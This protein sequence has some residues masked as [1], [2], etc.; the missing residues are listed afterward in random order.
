[1]KIFIAA[2]Y[3]LNNGD[4]AVLASTVK[5]IKEIYPGAVIIVSAVE[6]SRMPDNCDF[7]TVGWP[8]NNKITSAIWQNINVYSFPEWIK[9]RIS[10]KICDKEYLRE[11]KHAD[12][13]LLSGGHH[14]TDIL[15]VKSYYHLS[16]N[17][18]LPIFMKKTIHLL[19]QSIGPAS[20]E[21]IALDIKE[22]LESATTVAY[23]DDSS[24]EFLETLHG[25]FNKMEI[26]DLVY[27]LRPS[28]VIRKKDLVA[29]AL[30]HSYS[31]ERRNILDLTI[32]NLQK[33]IKYLLDEGKIVTI[34]PM[35]QGDNVY[36][37]MIKEALKDS[38]NI[39]NFS[40]GKNTNQVQDTID[41]FA[42]ASCVIAYKTHASIFS[43]ISETPLIGVAYHPK[44]IEF[45]QSMDLLDYAISDKEA[46]SDKLISLIK[47]IEEN[48][49]EIISKEQ[50][51]VDK[52]RNK[53]LEYLKQILKV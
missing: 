1:M 10:K 48:Y 33:T 28:R 34:V 21:K 8:F 50:I 9:I 19:P 53:I 38:T 13:V 40:L 11:L 23:R 46:T 24:A 36:Y 32:P 5:L 51:G 27:C 52:N 16:G 30:Y 26:P 29:V 22:I 17:F 18:I 4:R 3:N 12:I 37:E 2:H 43:M 31:A 15:G 49:D 41:Q 39:N 35:D 45:M 7:K 14:L 42:E 20:N 25:E 44:T 47:N 6:P